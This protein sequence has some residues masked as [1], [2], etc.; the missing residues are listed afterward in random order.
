MAFLV[1]RMLMVF[2]GYLSSKWHVQMEKNAA[3]GRT[4]SSVPLATPPPAALN[5]S[6]PKFGPLSP[7][8][9]NPLGDT[10]SINTKVEPTSFSLPPSFIEDDRTAIPALSRGPMHDQLELRQQFGDQRNERLPPGGLHP[11]AFF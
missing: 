4:P 1:I 7:V 2:S 6:S 9:T 11:T 3:A 5:L 8:N 10:K